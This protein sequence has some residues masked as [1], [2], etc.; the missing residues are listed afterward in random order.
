MICGCLAYIGFYAQAAVTGVVG[1]AIPWQVYSWIALLVAGLLGRRQIDLN[2][3]VLGAVV[4]AEFLLI[5]LLNAAIVAH[6]GRAALP[7]VV[8]DPRTLASGAPGVSIMLAF[9]SYI[10]FEA[11]VLFAPETRSPERS[12]PRAAY[13]AIILI[14]AFYVLT[15]WLGIGAIGVGHLREASADD[16]GEL[17]M[18]L[19]TQYFGPAAGQGLSIAMIL[20]VFAAMLASHNVNSRYVLTLARQGCA[21]RW[22]AALHPR[23]RSPHR[24]S[25]LISLL[26]IP[27][28]L[29]ASFTRL[30]P[31]TD[32]GGPALGLGI[33]GIIGMYALTSLAV[34]AYFQRIGRAQWWRTRL[35]PLLGFVCMAG[36][37]TL[38][39]LNFDVLT[40][41]H[42]RWA[43]LF[44]TAL[45]VLFLAGLAYEIA[46]RRLGKERHAGI[47]RQLGATAL[48]T[49]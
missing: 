5:M 2:V 30:D 41:A 18:R 48:A 33:M 24:G 27:F 35:A 13:G 14:G 47:S 45:L 21:P 20:S 38:A 34:I 44:P 46:L 3:Y 31:I 43:M 36:A 12:I 28:M 17:Y 1:L 25:L 49:Y 9:I 26:S 37:V 15:S 29:V 39:V 32:L 22:F 16:P 42:N 40:G 10:G 7:A 8:L 23:H 19:A 4:I 11:I 6:L